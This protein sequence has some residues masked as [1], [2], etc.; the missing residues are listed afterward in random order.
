MSTLD[1]GSS[2]NS[3]KINS[4]FAYLDEASNNS[5]TDTKSFTPKHLKDYK[6]EFLEF[7]N[8][9]MLSHK[10]DV[11]PPPAPTPKPKFTTSTKKISSETLNS[12]RDKIPKVN[13]AL[14]RKNSNHSPTP[15]Q[16]QHQHQAEVTS[17]N[18][19]RLI[20]EF[21]LKETV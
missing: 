13:N 7:N 9:N 2:A 8:E 14:A 11:S 6:Y 21:M 1:I 17:K 18:Y 12:E 19:V 15:A 4:I 20:F 16:N 3:E 5:N 10:R